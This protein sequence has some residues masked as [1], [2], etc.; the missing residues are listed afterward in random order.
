M[1]FMGGYMGMIVQSHSSNLKNSSW[2]SCRAGQPRA[3]H[4][5][6]IGVGGLRF[7]NPTCRLPTSSLA[8]DS[9]MPAV[10]L[11][12]ELTNKWRGDQLV[13]GD[14]LRDQPI[15]TGE[16]IQTVDSFRRNIC[17]IERRIARHQ[18]ADQRRLFRREKPG[19]HLCSQRRVSLEC[20]LG[21]YNGLHRGGGNLRLLVDQLVGRRQRRE[22]IQARS[23]RAI[24]APQ[25]KMNFCDTEL[26]ADGGTH[27]VAPI[28]IR[29]SLDRVDTIMPAP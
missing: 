3:R 13:V 17:I 29:A 6:R 15:C 1:Y 4:A 23:R 8:L 10:G 5:W 12:P 9:G 24:A 22:I 28:G 19:S 21:L 20:L 2:N 25:S 11:V 26:L 16:L 27:A 18:T 7:A 14:R